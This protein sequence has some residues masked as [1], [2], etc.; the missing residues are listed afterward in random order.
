LKIIFDMNLYVCIV[1]QEEQIK[2]HLY[3][4]VVRPRLSGVMHLSS[5]LFTYFIMEKYKLNTKQIILSEQNALKV[6]IFGTLCTIQT[7]LRQSLDS[8]IYVKLFC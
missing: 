1:F 8:Y 4:N 5:Y 2:L 7:L 6:T 3:L